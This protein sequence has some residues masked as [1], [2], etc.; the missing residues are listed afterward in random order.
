MKQDG[1]TS[2]KISQVKYKDIESLQVKINLYVSYKLTKTLMQPDKDPKTDLLKKKND[3]HYDKN[4][5]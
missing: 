3:N 2:L 1:L 4:V 5:I